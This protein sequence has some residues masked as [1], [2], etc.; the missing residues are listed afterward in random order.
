VTIT[1]ESVRRRLK[2]IRAAAG[3][4]ERAHSMEDALYRDVLQAIAKG[5]IDG[6]RLARLAL[7]ARRINFARWCA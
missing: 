3:D 1:L 7:N 2:E 4:D 5:H 6:S